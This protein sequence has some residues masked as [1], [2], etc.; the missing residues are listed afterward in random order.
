MARGE[1]GE[2]GHNIAR[3]DDAAK[4]TLVKSVRAI[5]KWMEEKDAISEDIKEEYKYLKGLGFDAS[6]VRELISEKRKR[7]KNPDKWDDK[8]NCKDLY[9][10]ALGMI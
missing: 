1:H 8:E 6:G 5:E 9:R 4:A 7:N 10:V 2:P 3:I